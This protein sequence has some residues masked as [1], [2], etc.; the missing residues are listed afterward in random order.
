MDVFPDLTGPLILMPSPEGS[1]TCAG[2]IQAIDDGIVS[3]DVIWQLREYVLPST[4]KPE[5]RM[6]TSGS[7]SV[8]T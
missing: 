2:F 5:A 7:G 8:L 6:I 4:G 1:A 3:L